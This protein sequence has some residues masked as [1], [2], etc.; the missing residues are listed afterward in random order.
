MNTSITEDNP[1][2][3]KSKL[4]IL[5]IGLHISCG[6]YLLCWWYSASGE[7]MSASFSNLLSSCDHF[8]AWVEPEV[9]N[10]AAGLQSFVQRVQW[11]GNP[12]LNWRPFT[13]NDR[14]A[15]QLFTPNEKCLKQ[16]S[17]TNY[18]TSWVKWRSC[19]TVQKWPFVEKYHGVMLRSKA[20]GFCNYWALACVNNVEEAG[21]CSTSV[22]IGVAARLENWKAWIHLD[23]AGKQSDQTHI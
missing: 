8:C 12:L 21:C 23:S 22:C 17:P 4:C 9:A 19:W 14:S 18:F 11:W 6:N 5:K 10:A 7:H 20:F 1:V 13:G 2:L 15:R 16:N 3:N